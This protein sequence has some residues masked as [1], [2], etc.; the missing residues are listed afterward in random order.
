MAFG[1]YVAF[2]VYGRSV[3]L[4]HGVRE[5]LDGGAMGWCHA[6]LVYVHEGAS[7]SPHHTQMTPPSG[8]PTGMMMPHPGHSQMVPP[9]HGQYPRGMAM[10]PPP[11]HAQ[12]LHHTFPHPQHPQLSHGMPASQMGGMPPSS[13]NQNNLMQNHD[14]RQTTARFEGSADAAQSQKVGVACGE[15]FLGS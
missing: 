1:G 5:C 4:S 6:G 9:P 3:Y 2:S 15:L 7:H 10:V 13:L 8:P 11:S 12:H 14:P